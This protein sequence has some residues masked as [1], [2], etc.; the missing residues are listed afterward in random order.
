MCSSIRNV[1]QK[2]LAI[3][4]LVV[5]DIT[6]FYARIC[7]L[8]SL[9]D[10]KRSAP[11]SQRVGTIEGKR[12]QQLLTDIHENCLML[13]AVQE[14]ITHFHKQMQK[15][16]S[17]KKKK[18]RIRCAHATLTKFIFRMNVSPSSI[19]FRLIMIEEKPS[20]IHWYLR[21]PYR[22]DIFATHIACIMYIQI[23]SYLTHLL[24]NYQTLNST[25]KHFS[26]R[27]RYYQCVQWTRGDTKYGT[28]EFRRNIAAADKYK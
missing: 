1:A 11:Y 14:I 8:W 18:P 7:V 9:S 3:E 28:I 27:H 13:S 16:T 4:R 5:H 25:Y 10:N 24:E 21:W 23:H 26:R 20:R 22:L 12:D 15:R 6:A 2:N 19:P 17:K